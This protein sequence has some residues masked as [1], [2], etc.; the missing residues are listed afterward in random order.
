MTAAMTY[1]MR[2]P[3]ASGRALLGG[4][5]GTGPAPEEL[6]LDAEL[7]ERLSD[8]VVHQV[9]ER[10]R[11]LLEARDR[12]EDDRP[13]ER[14]FVHEAKVV[15]IERRLADHQHELP[16]LFQMHVG[17]A[18]DEVVV[19][20]VRDRRHRPDAARGD[21]H[22]VRDE[23]ARGNR[24][25]E[26]LLVVNDVREAEDV[27]EAAVGLVRDGRLRARR[28]DEVE[29]DGAV[30]ADRLERSDA[31]DGARRAGDRE[32]DPTGLAHPR[33]VSADRSGRAWAGGAS[34]AVRSRRGRR[35]SRATVSSSRRG[36][37]A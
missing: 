12:R 34:A 26:I 15:R 10:L 37:S 5:L 17:R 13:R 30:R 8:A 21:E 9:Q 22:A 25:G 24:R 11:L 31:V 16:A 7:V 28:H 36:G 2:T 18:N 20:R 14:A 3:E 19:Q 35:G 27:R 29:L 1:W 23:R 33:A 4:A 6:V 32:D